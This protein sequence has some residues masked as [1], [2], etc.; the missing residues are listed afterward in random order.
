M[1]HLDSECYIIYLGK[2][3]D[4]YKPFLRIGNTAQ[5][6]ESIKALIYPIVVTDMLTGSPILE[7]DNLSSIVGDEF[8]YIGDP[9]TVER[10]KQFLRHQE[11]PSQAF[12]QTASDE[13]AD[14]GCF[15]YFYHDGNVRVTFDKAPVFN[16]RRREEQDRH[17]LQRAKTIKNHLLRN[18]LRY[19]QKEFQNPGF[20]VLQ[21]HT[22]LFSRGSVGAFDIPDDYFAQFAVA[23]IDPD[24]VTTVYA[25]DVSEG[26]IRLFKRVRSK[27]GR[28]HVLTDNPP[29]V[30][31][32]V[33]LFRVEQQLQLKSEVVKLHPD[34]FTPVLDFRVRKTGRTFVAEGDAFPLSLS[35]DD[36]L[37]AVARGTLAVSATKRGWFF[38]AQS[39]AQRGALLEGVPHLLLKGA[40]PVATG[41]VQRY[42]PA[43]LV[44]IEDLLSAPE[45]AAYSAVRAFFTDLA[46]GAGDLPGHVRKARVS[47]KGQPSPAWWMFAQN[48]AALAQSAALTEQS[49]RVRKSLD[50]LAE[51]LTLPGPPAEAPPPAVVCDLYVHE[52]GLFPLYRFAETVTSDRMRQ[53]QS[54][55]EAI[56]SEEQ[57][58]EPELFQ[59]EEK[60]LLELLA[61]LDTVKARTR[62]T[63]KDGAGSDATQVTTPSAADRRPVDEKRQDGAGA[64]EDERSGRSRWLL[65][66][67]LLLL[68]LGAGLL[69]FLATAPGRAIAQRLTGAPPSVAATD[70]PTRVPPQPGDPAAT[71]PDLVTPDEVDPAPE[72]DTDVTQVD[73]AEPAPTAPP[74]VATR[75]VP[76]PRDPLSEPEAVTAENFD[77]RVWEGIAD[78]EERRVAGDITI[79]VLDIIRLA[80]R[81]A[82][83]NG[84]R[85]M[86]APP[87]E[88]PN[89]EWIRPGAMVLLPDRQFV[90]VRDGETLWGVTADYIERQLA[91][92]V[93]RY[94]SLVNEHRQGELTTGDFLAEMRI[95][96]EFSN[97]EGFSRMLSRSV[98]EVSRG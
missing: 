70:D 12:E 31:N 87:E 96:Q 82:L 46:G 57:P 13:M 32:L 8:Q 47:G 50:A 77:P 18:P 14:M 76:A 81:I 42:L 23:G 73:P 27:D 90:T 86:G 45:T 66:A 36:S 64:E 95:L 69:F 65:I 39:G 54:I 80:N 6:P 29:A 68:L 83:A 30:Q 67:A 52:T 17:Y 79:T 21:G 34:R 53:A 35:V 43:K 51:A 94:Q 56:R 48:A 78:L 72:D 74:A 85:Q 59:K 91:R 92:D 75:P 41:D 1:F 60:R 33:E 89:P 9:A 49:D 2:D 55:A 16:L 26:L 40:P 84:Y 28:V 44:G 38:G 22:Y 25:P 62:R 3:L 19:P 24:R 61:S 88:G 5:L 15:V 4:D 93:P 63:K 20:F 58:Q 7:R 37:G 98:Q 97:S 71:D 10:Y 11:F